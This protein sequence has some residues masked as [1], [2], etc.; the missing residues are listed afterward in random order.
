MDY[1]AE[2]IRKVRNAVTQQRHDL[3][4]KMMPADDGGASYEIR[5]MIC[6]ERDNVLA[7]Y[8]AHGDNCPVPTE[9]A[10][11]AKK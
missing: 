3:L 4:Y 6:G 5:C 11:L 8:F 9:E 1:D 2:T 7:K 10:K